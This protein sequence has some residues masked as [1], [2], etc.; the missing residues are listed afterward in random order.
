MIIV[1]EVFAWPARWLYAWIGAV[2]SG[3]IL[4]T[5]FLAVV[6]V[7]AAFHSWIIQSILQER[8][9]YKAIFIGPAA[10]LLYIMAFL[11][12]IVSID[13]AT[14]AAVFFAWA[15]STLWTLIVG[16]ISYAAGELEGKAWNEYMSP[17]DIGFAAATAVL[18]A[19]GIL[20][21]MPFGEQISIAVAGYLVFAVVLLLVGLWRHDF[22]LP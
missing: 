4:D 8:W 1:K 6:S 7:V 15:G 10:I 9:G 13:A 14:R 2:Q 12:L 11:S 20:R 18:I 5:V 19:V 17:A 3:S 21:F 22:E 16:G